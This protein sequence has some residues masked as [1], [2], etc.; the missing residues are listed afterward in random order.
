MARNQTGFEALWESIARVPNTAM[1]VLKGFGGVGKNTGGVVG[2][3]ADT[4]AR[5]TSRTI[6]AGHWMMEK[7]PVLATVAGVVIFWKPIKNNVKKLFGMKDPQMSAQDQEIRQLRR[8]NAYLTE[9]QSRP[10]GPVDGRSSNYW[11]SLVNAGRGQ[12]PGTE[13]F[14]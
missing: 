12:T 9:L 13:G 4:A 1:E 8:E 5:Q 3:I 10:D 11:R 14:Q 2:K 7:F 6:N